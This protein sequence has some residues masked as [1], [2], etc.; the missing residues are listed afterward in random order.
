MAEDG[1]GTLV[2]LGQAQ[3][4]LERNTAKRGSQSSS[5]IYVV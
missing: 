5:G 2:K 1:E 4:M 3:K